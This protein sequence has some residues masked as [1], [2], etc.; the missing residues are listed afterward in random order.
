VIPSGQI[1]QTAAIA[2]HR[3]DDFGM[4]QSRVGPLKWIGP[5]TEAEIQRAGADK[6]GVVLYP[7][8][9]VSEHSETL[10]EL[11]IDYRRFAEIDGVPIYVR[12][13]TVGTHPLFIAG[14]AR[15]VRDAL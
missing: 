8:S 14:L 10:V 15:L 11:D 7:V 2:K 1:E 4:L 6:V 12:V 5:S 3:R 13:P 9:F